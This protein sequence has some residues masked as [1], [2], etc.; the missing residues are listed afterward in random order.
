MLTDLSVHNPFAKMRVCMEFKLCLDI[1]GSLC[2]F[3]RKA[4]FTHMTDCSID[5]SYS[6]EK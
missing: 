4:A 3:T 2:K 6:C 5:F 1:Q